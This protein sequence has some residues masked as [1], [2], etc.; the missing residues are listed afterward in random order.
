MFNLTDPVF[1]DESKARAVFE[2]QRWPDGPVCPFCAE[3]KDVVR[4][5]GAAAEKGLVLCRPCRKKFT[6]T[7]GTVMERSKIPLTKWLMTFRLMA[8]SK[9]GVSAHQVHRML[10]VT[11]KTAWFLCMRVREAMGLPKSSDPIG[12]KGK[13]IESDETFVGGKAKNVHRGKPIPKKHAV[14]ALVERGGQMRASHV[15]DVTAKTLREKM[16]TQTSRKSELH[17]DDALVYYWVGHEYARHR[18]VNHSAGE[19]V[20]KDGEAHVQS[21][22]SFFAILKRQVYGTHHAISEAHLNRYV[23]EAVFRWNNRIAL[24]VDDVA[25][26]NAAIRGAEGK[27]LTYRPSDKA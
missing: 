8:S 2:E 7:V 19:Y 13:I 22:E 6:V 5:G 27:R 26:M 25:R 21:A 14:H 9:K 4:L 1:H 16:V 24:G 18:A 11:Y 17:T 3:H 12:G 20:S 10:G 15:A 23:A